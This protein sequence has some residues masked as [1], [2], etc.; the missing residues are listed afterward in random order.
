MGKCQ[1]RGCGYY[2]KEARP[3]NWKNTKRVSVSPCKPIS[4]FTIWRSCLSYIL[5][6]I[7]DWAEACKTDSLEEMGQRFLPKQCS[8]CMWTNFAILSNTIWS[9]RKGWP[10][11]LLYALKCCVK[12]AH[13]WLRSWSFKI[14]ILLHQKHLTCVIV[15]WLSLGL[16]KWPVERKLLTHSQEVNLILQKCQCPFSNLGNLQNTSYLHYFSEST[17]PNPM[18]QQTSEEKVGHRSE[19]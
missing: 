5:L 16:R 8:V 11:M 13:S 6:Q 1:W 7:K 15:D 4:Q 10:S 14:L 12:E 9:S 3:Q 2:F 19:N 17:L 18:H